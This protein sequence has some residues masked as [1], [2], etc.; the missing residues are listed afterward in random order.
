MGAVVV[1]CVYAAATVR[2]RCVV[3]RC[4]GS[5]VVVGVVFVLTSLVLS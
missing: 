4:E 3:V 2:R 5:A 1:C